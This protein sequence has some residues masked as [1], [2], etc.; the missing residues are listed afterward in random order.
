MKKT[1]KASDFDSYSRLWAEREELFEGEICQSLDTNLHAATSPYRNVN[2]NKRPREDQK[3]NPPKR[4]KL[5][6]AAKKSKIEIPSPQLLKEQL[7]PK[8]LSNVFDEC[9]VILVNETI[10]PDESK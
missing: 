8:E 7:L 10:W 6:R 5:E 2:N 4:D 9:G 3:K 1:F